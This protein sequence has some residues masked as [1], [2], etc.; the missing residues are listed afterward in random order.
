MMRWLLA[1]LQPAIVGEVH[2]VTD[3]RDGDADAA[4]HPPVPRGPRSGKLLERMAAATR[5]TEC[6]CEDGADASEQ[7]A[8][9]H[10]WRH[11]LLVND[12]R[13]AHV[14]DKLCGESGGFELWVSGR[15][16]GEARGHGLSSRRGRRDR[17]PTL[18]HGWTRAARAQTR[19][20]RRAPQN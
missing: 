16:R 4:K 20:Q 2:V 18:T 1:R 9:E 17:L 15:G 5:G 13:V 8:E 14:G 6:D 12:E 10:A 7:H 19:A 11:G 3:E